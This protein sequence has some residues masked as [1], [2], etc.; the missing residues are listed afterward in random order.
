[1]TTKENHNLQAEI[2]SL[3]EYVGQ[4]VSKVCGKHLDITNSTE[5]IHPTK[6]VNKRQNHSTGTKH[7]SD[8]EIDKNKKPLG[9]KTGR[10]VD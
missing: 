7:I 3:R 9:F 4:L 10:N 5:N 1:M 8:D 2:Y 6:F